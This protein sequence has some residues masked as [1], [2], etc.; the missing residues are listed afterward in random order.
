MN[1]EKIV[2]LARQLKILR[3]EGEER[4]A[5]R[6]AE[7]L[8]FPYV[9]LSKVPAST[10]AA[11]LIPEE[12]ARAARVAAIELRTRAVALAAENPTTPEAQKAIKNLEEKKYEV[13][14]FVASLSGLE[15]VWGLYKFTKPSAETLT[16]RVRLEEEKVKELMGRLEDF[17]SVQKELRET[18]FVKTPPLILIETVLAG[19]IANRASDIHFETGEKKVKLRFRIDGL[20]HDVFADLPLQNYGAVLSRIKLIAT[21]KINVKDVAQDGRFSIS[22]GA[23]EIEIRVSIIPSEFGE[24]LVM[25]ILDP[26][27]TS[28]GLAGLGVRDDDLSII[29]RQLAKP[30]GLILN[31]GPTGSGKT[32]TLYSFLRHINDP[33]T[34]IVTLEDPIEY[35]LEGV[36]Q[37]QVDPAAGYTFA[38]G[39]RSVVRQDPDVILV[40]EIRDLETADI[41]LQAALTGHLVLSTLHTNDAVGA[42]P[43]LINLG[44]KPVSIGPALNLIIAQ[45]LVRKLCPQC[46]KPAELTADIRSKITRFLDELPKR[47][48]RSRYERYVIYEPGGCVKCNNFG[49]KGRTG[50]FEFFEGEAELEEVILKDA[51]EIALQK[52]VERQGMVAMQKDG[53]LK[54]LLGE[55][56]FKE[57]ENATGLIVW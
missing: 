8:G 40:G 46:K 22:L 9:D 1:P 5:R 53:I 48:D 50:I 36:E 2:E 49:Y 3:R 18:D 21:L 20:L 54:A 47:I 45:R 56:S 17:S 33:E 44:V 19:A 30:N 57:V 37:T 27:T 39:L 43:R 41:A 15:Q 55:I 42:I 24:T 28:I 16:G 14:T 4:M 23:K 51:S 29:T 10:E 32:T 31:T 12:E 7:Q 11:K 38:N 26:E 35:R 6:L 34:K 13:K 52:L 25:R